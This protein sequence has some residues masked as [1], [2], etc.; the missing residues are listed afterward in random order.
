MSPKKAWFPAVLV[1]FLANQLAAAGLKPGDILVM[2][3]ASIVA[4]DP[5]TGQQ[6][7]AFSGGLITG[8]SSITIDRNGD[9]IV[10]NS[11]PETAVLAILRIN[12]VTG[13]QAVVTT[14]G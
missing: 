2:D 14:N 10:M 3:P 9:M 5:V 11:T 6:T 8:L 4:V 12:P 1:F 13:S 7:V